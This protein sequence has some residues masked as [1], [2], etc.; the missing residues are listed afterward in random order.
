M[1][2]HKALAKYGYVSLDHASF[3]VIHA[4]GD[5]KDR[6]MPKASV[7]GLLRALQ[8]DG[9]CRSPK[10]LLDTTMARPVFRREIDSLDEGMTFFC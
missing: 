4:K 1:S 7:Q 3:M 8:M 6:R 5:A 9:F 2:P 10:P